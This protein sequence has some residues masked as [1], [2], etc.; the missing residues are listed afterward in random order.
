LE[1]E[2]PMS[3][4]TP[5]RR[6]RPS[7]EE[8]EN[9]LLKALGM[10]AAARRFS[11]DAGY[12]GARRGFDLRP[13]RKLI[14]E[15]ER[16]A[17]LVGSVPANYPPHVDFIMKAISALLPWYTRSL[18]ANSQKTAFVL[19]A[20]AEAVGDLAAQQQEFEAAMLNRGAAR[21]SDTA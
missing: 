5:D 18:R 19:A 16:D 20:L 15:L 8:L 14:A 3:E 9:R 4:R 1:N 17:S 13:L 7:S 6:S 10:P 2:I 11:A 12:V 21:N